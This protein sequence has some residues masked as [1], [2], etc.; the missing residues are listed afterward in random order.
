ML[1]LAVAIVVGELAVVVSASPLGG[2]AMRMLAKSC[3]A[4]PESR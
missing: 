4:T 3:S 1:L 2:L